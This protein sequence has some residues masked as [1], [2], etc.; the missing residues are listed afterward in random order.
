MN[1]QHNMTL[2]APNICKEWALPDDT[3]LTVVGSNPP[4]RAT[5]VDPS[6]QTQSIKKAD[7]DAP[8]NMPS[9]NKLGDIDDDDPDF[10]L[11]LEE[12]LD[13]EGQEEGQGQDDDEGQDEDDR[14]RSANKAPHTPSP[15]KTI[16]IID[17]YKDWDNGEP[18]SLEGRNSIMNMKSDYERARAM[19]TRRNERKLR[20]L[21]VKNEIRELFKMNKDKSK[22]GK[23][24]RVKSNLTSTTAATTSASNEEVRGT[25][26]LRT[27]GHSPVPLSSRVLDS[28]ASTDQLQDTSA[29]ESIPTTS[30]ST[31]SRPPNSTLDIPSP[32]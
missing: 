7:N 11:L 14:S 13:D 25:H 23:K 4:S 20:E 6:P 15:K 27:D 30:E 19:N 28:K 29:L 22:A 1:L 9:H 3:D 32:A 24:T 26:S 21:E 31:Q 5:T 10:E 18:L 8:A 16:P 12:Q 17:H 2:L